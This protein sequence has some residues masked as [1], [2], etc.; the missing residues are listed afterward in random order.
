LRISKITNKVVSRFTRA[1]ITDGISISGTEIPAYSSI[2]EVASYKAIVL[3]TLFGKSICY[4]QKSS[5]YPFYIL[6][7]I[8]DPYFVKNIQ[9]FFFFSLLLLLSCW[10][11]IS[12]VLRKKSD[13]LE[14]KFYQVNKRMVLLRIMANNNCTRGSD[15]QDID[16]FK[17]NEILSNQVKREV[18]F[19]GFLSN[20]NELID[21]S[22]QYY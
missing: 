8:K 16:Y 22:Y 15:L 11:Y 13:F 7:C 4:Q 2:Q 9:Q 17:G 10:I 5:K 14:E 12:F 3:Q 20:I 19:E 18:S 1:G 6:L 21:L